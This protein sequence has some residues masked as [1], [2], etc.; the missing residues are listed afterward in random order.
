MDEKIKRQQVYYAR[1]ELGLCVKCGVEI[2]HSEGKTY[3]MCSECREK[4]KKAQAISEMREYRRRYMKEYRKKEKL[5]EK[6]E[7]TMCKTKSS[8][9]K[10]L[11]SLRREI[12]EDHKCWNC[13]WSKWHG[14]R[15][16]CPLIGCVKGPMKQ[17][18]QNEDHVD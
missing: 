4:A 9:E 10:S 3:A 17:E 8:A 12:P 18:E 13:V 16:F 14:D 2:E 15:F 5:I 7:L 6:S 1:R 11:S